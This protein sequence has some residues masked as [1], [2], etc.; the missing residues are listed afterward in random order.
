MTLTEG[1]LKERIERLEKRFEAIER[2]M[3]DLSGII[4]QVDA[5]LGPLRRIHRHMK[6]WEDTE[7]R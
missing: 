4:R 6:L 1:E 5:D 3:K 7:G 2:L